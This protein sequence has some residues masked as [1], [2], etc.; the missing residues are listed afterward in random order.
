M[1]LNPAYAGED[2]PIIAEFD[3]GTTDPDDTTADGT[4]DATITI[5][6]ADT[7]TEDVSAVAMTHESTGTFEYVWDTTAAGAGSYIVEVTAEF[8]GETKIVKD[9]I[10]VR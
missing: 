4:A 1:A 10:R 2:V 5:T 6:D 9:R 8:G 3:D 7:D